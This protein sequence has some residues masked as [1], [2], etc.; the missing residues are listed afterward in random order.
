MPGPRTSPP[1]LGE[2]TA[3]LDLRH[4]EMAP[5]ACRER[6]AGGVAVATVP[7]DPGPAAAGADRIAVPGGGRAAALGPPGAVP[8][9]GSRGLL[10]RH[11]VE[12]ISRPRTGVRRVNPARG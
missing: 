2:P 10:R 3:A 4:R 5:R 1:L 8:T 12:A 6:A 9:R 11:P 7:H